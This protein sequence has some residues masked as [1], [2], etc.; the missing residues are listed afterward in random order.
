MFSKL[1]AEEDEHKLKQRFQTMCSLII[2]I[3]YVNM[4][5][6]YFRIRFSRNSTMYENVKFTLILSG[7]LIV[8][9]SKLVFIS[10]N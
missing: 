6:M 3:L 2:R 8:Y 10:A 5:E 9:I 1:S 4:P 7:K